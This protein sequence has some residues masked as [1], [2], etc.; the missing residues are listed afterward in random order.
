MK[1]S[2]A[3]ESASRS[4]SEISERFSGTRNAWEWRVINTE[5]ENVISCIYSIRWTIFS[6]GIYT[7]V[8]CCRIYVITWWLITM[9]ENENYCSCLFTLYTRTLAKLTS[10]FHEKIPQTVYVHTIASLR[11]LVSNC[12]DLFPRLSIRFARY[13]SCA[14][15]LQCKW[16]VLF[17]GSKKP[18]EQSAPWSVGV[19]DSRTISTTIDLQTASH[20]FDD[21]AN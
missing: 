7:T 10:K 5:I 21:S 17:V 20:R 1:T 3:K 18:T 15:L 6:W 2:Y 12:L 8:I 14:K 16:R 11:T 9:S 13:L 19:L 4:Y